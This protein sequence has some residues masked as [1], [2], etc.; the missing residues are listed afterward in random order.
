MERLISVFGIVVLISVAWLLSCARNKICWRTVSW[1]LGLQVIAAL[2]VLGIPVL[3][4]PGI[5]GG[6][7]SSANSFFIAI[8][9]YTAEGTR[10][11]FGPIVDIEKMGGVALA[12][13]VL[14]V[15]IFFSAFMAML[16]YLGIMQKLVGVL[17]RI[18]QY[19]MKTSGAETLATAANIFIGQTEAPLMVRPYLDKMTKSELMVL[20]VGGMATV[21]GSVLGLYVASLKDFIPG[22]A[23]H[24][25]TASVM[26]APAA[27]MIAK[28]MYPETEKAQ[29]QGTH[30]IVL[31]KLDHNILEALT[32]GTREGMHLAFN[33]GAM[34][35]S[36]I[37]LVA[38]FNG[39][40]GYIGELIN[41]GSWGQ[42]L[43]PDKLLALNNGEA[44]L[45][46]ELIF[47]WFFTP[48]AFLLGIPWHEASLAAAFLGQKIVLN[49]FV[50]YIN[51]SQVASQ[52]SERTLIILS[53][54][55]C[56]FANFSSIAIQIGG[57][58]SLAPSRQKEFAQLG[59]KAMIGGSLAA[60]ITA[61]LVS[62]II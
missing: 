12:F 3:E 48:L 36:F 55:L 8:F 11:L 16:Y 5:L 57:L 28:I 62:L 17:S 25:L 61:A 43:V 33:V 53:Y 26:S 50:A 10:F 39:C 21:A 60:F 44:K 30:K 32:R 46:L 51:M 58:G 2:L 1:G 34:L 22:I 14:P 45:S 9:N 18:M 7:F 15:I 42:A 27:L 54:A 19:T 56:G 6:L 24:L 20:M 37:A 35:L 23:G 31:P 41:F 4:V 38:F 52:F 40:F 59:F 47:A 49:E 29:T 13:S